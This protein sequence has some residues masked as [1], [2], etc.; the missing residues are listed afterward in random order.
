[1]G[2][3]D[4]VSNTP[5]LSVDPFL[6]SSVGNSCIFPARGNS[7][8]GRSSGL[9]SSLLSSVHEAV[10]KDWLKKILPHEQIGESTEA[11]MVA[12]RSG[13]LLCKVRFKLPS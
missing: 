2:S 4:S 13:E 10:V 11:V 6:P 1:M 7:G 12:L 9:R 3:S 8:V 5:R